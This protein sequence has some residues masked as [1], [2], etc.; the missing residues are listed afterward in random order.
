MPSASPTVPWFMLWKK[1]QLEKIIIVTL[2]TC[3]LDKVDVFYLNI[4]ILIVSKYRRCS[5][6]SYTSIGNTK[7]ESDVCVCLFYVL[8]LF[9]S[10]GGRMRALNSEYIL[11][12]WPSCYRLDVMKSAHLISLHVCSLWSELICWHH[13]V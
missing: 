3:F 2:V 8:Y 11:T 5:I 9:P 4:Y 10:R 13:A 12:N 1:T 7:S 6:N